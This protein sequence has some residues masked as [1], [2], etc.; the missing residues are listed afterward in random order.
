MVNAQQAHKFVGEV[1]ARPRLRREELDESL[2]FRRGYE[3]DPSPIYF[4]GQQWRIIRT[5]D[6]FYFIKLYSFIYNN[7]RVIA[8]LVIK[9][10]VL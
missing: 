9:Y 1:R 3:I 6:F 4:M 5:G 8:I 10:F 7:M 2:L